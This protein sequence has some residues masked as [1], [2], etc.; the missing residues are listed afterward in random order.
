MKM[1]KSKK[2]AGK[3][4]RNKV[5][6]KKKVLRSWAKIGAGEYSN[7]SCMVVCDDDPTSRVRPSIRPVRIRIDRPGYKRG[8]VIDLK[9]TH[10]EAKKVAFGIISALAE[11]RAVR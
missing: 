9:L 7:A 6:V 2:K 10:S 5:P 4:V 3:L 8:S 1:A 11:A